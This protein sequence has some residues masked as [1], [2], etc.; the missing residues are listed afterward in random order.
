MPSVGRW[1][2]E[3]TPASSIKPRA[4]RW[5]WPQWLAKGKLT[6]LAGAGGSGK[7]TLAI[8][9]IATLTNGRHWPD[10]TGCHKRG[11]A[12]IWSSE[13]DP[14][15]TLIPR[16]I[17]AGADLT[18]V[19][20]IEGRINAAGER[21]PFDPATDFDLLREAVERIGGAALLM[22]DPLVNMVR[23]DMHK[24]NDVRRS[25]QV[26]VDF[27][28]THG[29]AVLGI[30][31]F[32]KGSNTSNPAERVIGS[33]AFG[34]LARTVLVAAKSSDSD[35]RVLARAKSNISD[36]QG[37]VGYTIETCLLDEG[38]ETTR[39]VWGASIEG[40]AGEILA[41]VECAGSEDESGDDPAEALRRILRDGPIGGKLAKQLMAENGY[42]TKQTRTARERLDVVACREGFGKDMTTY[43]SLP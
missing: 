2:A 19:H 3:L 37:G 26:V 21:E 17:A 36:D 20:I 23:G 28:E 10:G 38:I 7:T 22:L 30:T 39:V 43:W 5:L 11:N 6:V 16:L 42:T 35:S 27:A 31:H 9:L 14:A 41:E 15:D 32:S 4:I 40:S 18:R 29:C 25:L 12:L 24:A 8:G 34:A 33:Q 1:A 13:D